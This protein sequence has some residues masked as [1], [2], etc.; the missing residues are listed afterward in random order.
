MRARSGALLL[1]LAGAF[2]AAAQG[3]PDAA[4]IYAEKC[5][6]CHLP[7]GKAPVKEMSF[8]EGSWKHGTKI[9][10]LV[11]VI[12]EGVDGTAMLPFKDQLDKNE[13]EAL[14]R[15]VRAF[16]KRLKPE[17]NAKGKK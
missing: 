4:Q 6:A 16:D 15:Y 9:A 7:E 10:D 12:R 14:A 5:Q 17:P 2:R 11:R 3:P 8:A 1:S 13:I